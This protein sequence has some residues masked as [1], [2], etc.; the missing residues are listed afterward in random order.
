MILTHKA[1]T[2]DEPEYRIVCQKQV[3]EDANLEFIALYTI[4]VI[5]DHPT[6]KTSIFLD[7]FYDSEEEAVCRAVALKENLPAGMLLSNT[8]F[9]S[10]LRNVMALDRTETEELIKRLSWEQAFKSLDPN[11]ES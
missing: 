8:P 7:S 3:L 6:E 5:E 11:P 1:R 2:P 10:H 9:F 4:Y